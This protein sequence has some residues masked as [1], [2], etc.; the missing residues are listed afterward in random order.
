MIKTKISKPRT[1]NINLKNPGNKMAR[2]IST[3][4]KTTNK[5][6]IVLTSLSD[7]GL[8]EDTSTQLLMLS[9]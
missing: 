7:P 8:Q 3:S 6:N 1:K 9:L 5:D 4:I 2:N